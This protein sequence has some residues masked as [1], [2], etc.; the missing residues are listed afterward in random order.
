MPLLSEERVYPNEQAL[1]DLVATERV[2]R[3][4]A[5]AYSTHACTMDITARIDASPSASATALALG[6]TVQWRP[7][8][9]ASDFT[10]SLTTRL[11]LTRHPA[12]R[13][14]PQT[15]ACLVRERLL[16]RPLPA[17]SPCPT[18]PDGHKV[19]LQRLKTDTGPIYPKSCP[20]HRLPLPLIAHSAAAT[21]YLR[22]IWA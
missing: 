22:W 15:R 10:P 18:S 11:Q 5:L 3:R 7:G 13:R 2:E 17:I 21:P 9:A 16:L 12:N 14:S 8:P 4:R 19:S 1:I 6:N 20:D